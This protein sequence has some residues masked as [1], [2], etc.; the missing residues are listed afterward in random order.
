MDIK[1]FIDSETGAFGVAACEQ[2]YLA[3]RSKKQGRSTWLQ[4]R[5]NRHWIVSLHEAMRFA[6]GLIDTREANP[7]DI[8]IPWAIPEGITPENGVVP[9]MPEEPEAEPSITI[10]LPIEDLP[11]PGVEVGPTDASIDGGSAV[12]ED[13]HPLLAETIATREVWLSKAAQR[14]EPWLMNSGVAAASLPTYRVSCGFPKGGKGGRGATIGQCWSADASKDKAREIFVS[15]TLDNPVDVLSTLLHEMCHAMLPSGVGHKG[16]FI[17][18]AK[19]VGFTKPWTQT[20]CTDALTAKLTTVS[21]DLGP[22][23]H[24]SLNPKMVK[25]QT[26]RLILSVCGP[27]DT[28]GEPGCGA[29]WR[30][31]QQVLDANDALVLAGGAVNAGLRCPCGGVISPDN[32]E[33]A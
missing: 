9:A 2:D 6:E 14:F 33:G 17:K 29:K 3:T 11:T 32:A 7:L 24:A 27:N 20:P 23:P 18:V 1:S 15:P 8:T 30:S 26:T 12:I 25:K 31:S 13:P 28:N 16:D 19:A 5:R 22:Y 4:L 10:E 21:E